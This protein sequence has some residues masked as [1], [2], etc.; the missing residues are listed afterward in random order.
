MSESDHCPDQETLVKWN[1]GTLAN[2]QF[3]S[4]CD[5]IEACADCQQRIEAIEDRSQGVSKAFAGITMADLD[6]ARLQIE[7]ESPAVKAVSSWL[8][9]MQSSRSASFVPTLKVPCELRQYDV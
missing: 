1:E 8:E 6:R 7:A 9:G 3:E 4:I 2:S 5:H